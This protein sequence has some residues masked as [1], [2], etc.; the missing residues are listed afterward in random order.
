PHEGDQQRRQVG[1]DPEH[2]HLRDDADLEEDDRDRERADAQD[3]RRGGRAGHPPAPVDAS[4][5]PCAVV[6]WFWPGGSEAISD[7]SPD[8]VPL[9]GAVRTST[10]SRLWRFAI[11]RTLTDV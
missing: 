5:S 3:E 6:S 10:T 9:A 2:G 1:V 4:C 11:G 8:A 7:F